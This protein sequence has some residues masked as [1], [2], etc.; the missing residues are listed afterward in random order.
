MFAVIFSQENTVNRSRTGSFSNDDDSEKQKSVWICATC[1]GNRI[2][3]RRQ[4]LTPKFYSSIQDKQFVVVKCAKCRATAVLTDL[5]T[6]SVLSPRRVAATCR[7][8]HSDLSGNFTSEVVQW[9]Y[10]NVQKKCAARAKSSTCCCFARQTSTFLLGVL[11]SLL[12]AVA[13]IARLSYE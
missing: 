6:R 7:L 11:V 3:L 13:V 1:W 9:L 12:I 8:L 10:R 5:N 4:R 2:L